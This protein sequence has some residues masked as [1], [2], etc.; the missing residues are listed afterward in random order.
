MKMGKTKTLPLNKRALGALVVLA[1]WSAIVFIS[2][3]W[4]M[5]QEEKHTLDLVQSEAR[6]HFNH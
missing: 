5:A 3:Q 1:V 2:L 4:N 6:I